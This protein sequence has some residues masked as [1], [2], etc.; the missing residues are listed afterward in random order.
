M[1]SVNLLEIVKEV[2]VKDLPTGAKSSFARAIKAERV[3]GET[4][5]E[6]EQFLLD[7]IAKLS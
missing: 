2:G 4:T 1:L 5:P 6:A 7:A 3:A